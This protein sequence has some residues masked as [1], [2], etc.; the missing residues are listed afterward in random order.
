MTRIAA[1]VLLS[2]SLLFFGSQAAFASRSAAQNICEIIGIVQS[3]KKRKVDHGPEMDQIAG[4][5]RYVTYFDIT[6]DVYHSNLAID[7]NVGSDCVLKSIPEVKT[8][9]LGEKTNFFDKKPKSGECIKGQVE[10]F[11]SPGI[12]GDWL[13]NIEYLEAEDCEAK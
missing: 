5:Q 9:Q 11:A 6:I 4:G 3:I 12:F 2:C 10:F 8:Y 13:K 1:L 7:Y